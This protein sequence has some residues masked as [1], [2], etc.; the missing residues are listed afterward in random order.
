M[1]MH[2]LMWVYVLYCLRMRGWSEG[3]R[4]LIA[5]WISRDRTVWLC[6]PLG[7]RKK[8]KGDLG[9]TYEGEEGSR[10]DRKVSAERYTR[11]QSTQPQWED[12]FYWL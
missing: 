11:K 6:R 4:L 7:M 8:E 9:G 10:Q 2:I 12:P 1:H 5:I 3:I